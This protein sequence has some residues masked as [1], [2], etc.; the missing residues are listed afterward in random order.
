MSLFS[1]FQKSHPLLTPLPAQPVI[2]IMLPNYNHAQYLKDNIEGLQAQTYAHWELNIVDD[3]STDGSVA[4]IQE[5]AAKDPRIKPIV[6]E[7]N[8]GVMPAAHAAFDAC[9]GEL[10]YCSAADDYLCNPHFFADAVAALR[11]QPAAGYF[12]RARVI[13]G[14]TGAEKWVMGGAPKPGFNAPRDSLEAFLHSKIFVPGVSVIFRRQLII[15]AGGYDEALG[16]QCDYFLNHALPALG[17]VIFSMDVVANSRLIEKSFSA[18]ASD[19]DFFRRHALVEQKIRAFPL[20]YRY[21]PAWFQHWRENIINGKFAFVRQKRLVEFVRQELA[22]VEGWER[23]TI[24]PRYFTLAEQFL[25]ALSPIAED[26]EAKAKKAHA[27][28]DAHHGA[29]G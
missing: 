23:S 20:G 14:E 18:S 15:A 19:D 4:L 28:F 10:L 25:T 11:R 13:D 29:A 17:G 26:V 22:S 6:F 2:S 5:Y 12:G 7:K 3:G 24:D 9:T 27:I 1:R 21:D 8:R 16:P